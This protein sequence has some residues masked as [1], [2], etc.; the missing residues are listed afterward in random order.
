MNKNEWE[1]IDNDQYFKNVFNNKFNCVYYTPQY[2]Q[3]NTYLFANH[4]GK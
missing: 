4:I 2:L 3:N 1:S